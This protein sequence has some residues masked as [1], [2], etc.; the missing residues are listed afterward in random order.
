MWEL[1]GEPVPVMEWLSV[2][3]GVGVAERLWE[4]VLVRLAEDDIV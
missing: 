2:L 4:V 3:L 1:E